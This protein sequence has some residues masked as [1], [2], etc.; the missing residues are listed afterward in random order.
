VGDAPGV[1]GGVD[2]VATAVV[3][4]HVPEA[5]MKGKK[6]MGSVTCPSQIW[7][8]RM[9]PRRPGLIAASWRR[10]RR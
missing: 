10:G 2:S 3:A 9:R 6:A 4:V 8:G 1:D 7:R 5:D